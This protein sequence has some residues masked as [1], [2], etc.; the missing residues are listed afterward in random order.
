M[1]A[2]LSVIVSGKADVRLDGEKVAELGDGQFV[3]QIALSLVRRLPS[4]S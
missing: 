2:R 1:L 3:G 4:A